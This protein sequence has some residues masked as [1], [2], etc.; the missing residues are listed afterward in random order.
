MARFLTGQAVPE[1]IV[2]V[3]NEALSTPQGQ[4][5][6]GML[7]GF[8]SSINHSNQA[9]A[10]DPLGVPQPAA[11]PPAG[12]PPA[13]AA[14]AAV[15]AWYDEV[16]VAAAPPAAA[17]ASTDADETAAALREVLAAGTEA[18]RACER[19]SNL[20]PAGSADPLI[21]CS[22]RALSGLTTL[23]KV[24]LNLIEHPE[25]PKFRK[26]KMSNAAFSRKVHPFVG[27]CRLRRR[28]PTPP[29][30]VPPP[31]P[32]LATHRMPSFSTRQVL[33][34]AGGTDL[35]LCLGFT[36]DTV[37]SPNPNPH[38]RHSTFTLTAH[39]APF[40]THLSP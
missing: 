21:P 12:A 25:D 15:A 7:E 23:R 2:N 36:P 24:A 6:R 22:H 20:R 40:T 39:H 29:H 1:R 35:F 32:H 5:L 38:P 27:P 11:L 3:A 10:L 26:I 4:A 13:A 16:A 37:W 34:C 30:A 17:A 28:R 8:Q 33:E 14:T 9:N 19:H 18:A 31:G